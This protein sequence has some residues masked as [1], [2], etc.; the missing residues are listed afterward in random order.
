MLVD[1]GCSRSTAASWVARACGSGGSILAVDGSE[2]RARGEAKVT[3]QVRGYTVTLNCLIADRLVGGLDVILGQ[4]FGREVGGVATMGREARFGVWKQL[5]SEIGAP[6]VSVKPGP[7]SVTDSDFSAEFD[8]SVWTVCWNWKEGQPQ[9]LRNTVGC[10]DS[11]RSDETREKFAEEVERWIHEGYLKPCASSEKG[12]VLPLMAVVQANKQKV[13][14]VL[15]FRELNA[16]VSSHPG[17]DAA[18][19]NETL[20]RWRRMPGNTKIVDLK[21]AYLQV[22]VNK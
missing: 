15:D 5:A 22:R 16:H 20:R 21:S 1:S 9:E 4:D 11:A 14:P 10:Y 12:G 19:C 2:V 8:G 6:A 3:V 13:R 18:V 17:S 7:L